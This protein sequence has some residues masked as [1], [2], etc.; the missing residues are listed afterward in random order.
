MTKEN[1]IPFKKEVK[2]ETLSEQEIK[3]L[4]GTNKDTYKRKKGRIKSK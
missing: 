4:M 1:V 2:K 3:E